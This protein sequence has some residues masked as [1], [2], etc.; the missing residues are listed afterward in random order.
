MT[1]YHALKW[2]RDLSPT[3]TLSICDCT[4]NQL[5]KIL[6]FQT[7]SMEGERKKK[8]LLITEISSL[9]ELNPRSHKWWWTVAEGMLGL[10]VHSHRRCR[11]T[12]PTEHMRRNVVFKTWGELL[13]L[14][15]TVSLPLHPQVLFGGCKMCSA[16]IELWRRNYAL[17]T[18]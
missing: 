4:I 2:W 13:A 16:L 6:C 11:A 7:N 18:V 5:R 12:A 17:L 10:T 3:T 15:S 8:W 9:D 1:W 14:L